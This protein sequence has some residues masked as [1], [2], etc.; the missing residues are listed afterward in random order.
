MIQAQIAKID[1]MLESSTSFASLAK[2]KLMGDEN[3]ANHLSLVKPVT[4]YTSISSDGNYR[5]FSVTSEV[6]KDYNVT[7]VSSEATDLVNDYLKSEEFAPY[8]DIVQVEFIGESEEIMEMVGNMF[9]ALLIGALLVYMVMAIQFQSLL[10]PLIILGTL[11][12]AFTGGLGFILIFNVQFSIIAIMGL[13][14][15][16]GVA[17]N[18]GIVLIDYINQLREEGYTVRKACIEASKTRLRPIL[19]TSITTIVALIFSAIGMSNGSELL[20]PLSIT[21]IGGLIFSTIL[22]LVVIPAIY[23]AVNFKTVKKEEQEELK[24]N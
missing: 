6:S 2:G 7:K 5:Y 4:G 16:V 14:V 13:I 1:A 22:T 8:K 3:D 15:L 17:V 19:M 20:Q 11:P 24:E 21:S 12:L 18:N 9:I 10:Y 23:M